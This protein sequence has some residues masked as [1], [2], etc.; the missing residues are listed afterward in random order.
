M[1]HYVFRKPDLDTCLTAWL[2]GYRPGFRVRVCHS[3]ANSAELDSREIVCIEC[4]G[5][6]MAEQNN[7]DHHDTS[8]DLPPACVQ[9]YEFFSCKNRQIKTIVDYVAAVDLGAPGISKAFAGCT[10]TTLSMLYSGMRTLIKAPV[11]QLDMGVKLLDAM[12]D[13]EVSPTNMDDYILSNPGMQPFVVAYH[14]ARK[15]LYSRMECIIK[16][17]TNSGKSG[18]FLDCDAP[19]IHGL[20]RSMGADVSVASGLEGK[21]HVTISCI[22]SLTHG[23]KQALHQLKRLE[24]GWGGRPEQGIIG[25]PIMGTV[26]DDITVINIL[27]SNL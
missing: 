3:M 16:F 20:L 8:C 17:K 27:S 4:G 10:K 7:Y 11:S 2:T 6:G 19:G 23:L 14:S 9:A 22:P 15:Q 18:M 24:S 25:A 1:R 12:I 13:N 5:S 21:R 26:L